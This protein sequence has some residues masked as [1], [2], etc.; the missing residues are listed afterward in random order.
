LAGQ[1]VLG[2]L[3]LQVFFFSSFVGIDLPTATQ[4]NLVRYYRTQANELLQDV[5]IYTP[6]KYLVKFERYLPTVPQ[7]DGPVR[8][9]LYAPQAPIAIFLGYVL[10]WPIATIAAG[11]FLA[12]GI[13]GPV[14]GIN[15]FAAGGGAD[16]YQ[17]PGFGYLIGML[18]A[19]YVVAKI[20]AEKRTSLRQIAALAAGIVSLHLTGLTY[21]I[22][23]ALLCAVVDVSRPEWLGWV[24]DQAR[25]MS[26]YPLPYD[27]L[28]ALILMGAA[29]PLRYLVALLTAPD[30]A[31][32]TKNDIIA[33]RQIE[34]LLH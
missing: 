31:L 26:W 11:L 25:N 16:Y 2:L 15:P 33:Q 9:T 6:E 30:I 12:I 4:R 10:G 13:I 3:G 7:P 14:F 5:R 22:G 1:L 28:F 29:F 8:Y 21:L 18:V 27:A 34:E 23:S 32:K 20:T 17:Q 19:T 24:F